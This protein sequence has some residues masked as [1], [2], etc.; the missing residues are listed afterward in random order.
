MPT[1]IKRIELKNFLS[2]GPDSPAVELGPLNVLIGPNGSGKSNLV[3]ALSFLHRLPEGLEHARTVLGDPSTVVWSG[4]GSEFA[5]TVDLCSHTI[6]SSPKYQI[7]IRVGGGGQY[8]LLRELIV[9]QTHLDEKT[10]VFL[11]EPREVVYYN[12]NGTVATIRDAAASETQAA[13][14]RVDTEDKFRVEETILAQ[15]A[16]PTEYPLI[17]YVADSFKF[18][19]AF[20]SWPFGWDSQARNA[21]TTSQPANRVDEDWRNYQLVLNRICGEPKV[22]ARVLHFL[23]ALAPGLRDIGFDTLGGAGTLRV[24]EGDRNVTMDRLSDGTVRVLAM[25]AVFCHPKPP[26]LIIFEEPE[27]GLHPDMIPTLADLLREASERTQ[28]VVTTHSDILV[29]CFTATPKVVLVCEKRNGQTH[30]QQARPST[31][32]M[33]KG[34]APLS[35][36]VQ[37]IRGSIG[38][39]RW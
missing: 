19:S 10:G 8:W 7:G 3:N 28:V 13:N 1:L 36:G 17:H 26:P 12:G 30:I 23:D 16:Y 34:G 38:G 4:K 14:R 6:E 5:L 20:R 27:M 32:P 33:K 31:I 24:T 11:E 37:W 39:K 18:T 9:G 15:R 29:D 35:L 2:F 21:Q 25:L 22:K